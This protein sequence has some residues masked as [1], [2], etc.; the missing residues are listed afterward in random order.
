MS[1]Y[2]WHM[3][4]LWPSLHILLDLYRFISRCFKHSTRHR[5][6]VHVD[7]EQLPPILSG[8]ACCHP[9]Q[10][11]IW[12][13]C[14]SGSVIF[15]LWMLDLQAFDKH[16]VI[17]WC[18]R[19]GKGI[20]FANITRVEICYFYFVQFAS[21]KILCLQ[22]MWSIIRHMTNNSLNNILVS[23]YYQ[24]ILAYHRYICISVYCM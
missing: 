23:W 9:W 18:I 5:K 7:L 6:F 8:M 24:P 13:N 14:F 20:A 17:L 15:V 10:E 21:H 4:S 1:L 22:N 16:A 11:F 2:I 12:W 19:V 3:I